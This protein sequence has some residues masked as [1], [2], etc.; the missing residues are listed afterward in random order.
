LSAARLGV[1]LH[2]RAGDFAVRKFGEE[3]MVAGDLPFFIGEAY[4]ELT[5]IVK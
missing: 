4:K 2:G 1:F 3:S 5:S